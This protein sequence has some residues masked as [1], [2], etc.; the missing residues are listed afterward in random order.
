MMYP[1]SLDPA[2]GGRAFRASNGELGIRLEDAKAFLEA[3]RRDQAEV[4]GWELWVIHH[5][6]ADA[7]DS[8]VEQPGVWCGG[9][10]LKA[11]GTAIFHGEGDA[12]ASEEQLSRYD[13][14]AE[15][16]PDYLP[17]VRLNF[18]LGD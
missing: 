18:T 13:F 3:C 7:S 14:E 16:A 12:D 5:R 6:W 8:V 2:I 17:L 11:G 9:V 4:F 15:I 10:P 1:A